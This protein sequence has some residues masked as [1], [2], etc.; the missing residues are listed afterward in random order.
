[1]LVTATGRSVASTWTATTAAATDSDDDE[2]EDT[3]PRFES[4]DVERWPGHFR[5]LSH[6]HDQ[7]GGP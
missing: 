3:R 5:S 7:C 1:M 4:Y 2:H 6:E